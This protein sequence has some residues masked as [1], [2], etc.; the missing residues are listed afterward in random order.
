[1][2]E[3]KKKKGNPKDR[4][5]FESRNEFLSEEHCYFLLDIMRDFKKIMYK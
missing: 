3:W 5:S 4:I 1:M 2:N